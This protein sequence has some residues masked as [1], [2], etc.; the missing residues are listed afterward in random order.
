[1]DE[2][3]GGQGT[4][5]DSGIALRIGELSSCP[6]DARL[7][8]SHIPDFHD[9]IEHPVRTAGGDLEVPETISPTPHKKRPIL[10][11]QETLALLLS[12]PSLGVCV[13]HRGSIQAVG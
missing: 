13:E 8:R 10:D 4:L 7:E 12:P 11:A 9:R 6:I 1:M 5:P 2:A 3:V